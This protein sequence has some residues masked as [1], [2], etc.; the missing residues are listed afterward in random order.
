M[1]TRLEDF[2]D[3]LREREP[4]EERPFR[5]TREAMA[6]MVIENPELAGASM[7]VGNWEAGEI[8]ACTLVYPTLKEAQDWMKSP[9]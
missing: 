6:R 4:G 9:W 3:A 1:S 7:D 2:K 8:G 5:K